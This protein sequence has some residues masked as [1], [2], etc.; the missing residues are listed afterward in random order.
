ME[1][2]LL[3]V[4]IAM[5]SFH[6][7]YWLFLV[8]APCCVTH[9]ASLDDNKGEKGYWAATAVG[10]V[11]AALLTVLCAG[12]LV[13]EPLLFSS[14]DF[15]RSTNLSQLC[16]KIFI[17]YIVNDLA[18][19]LYFGS[20]WPGW[21]SNL[22]HHVLVL[23]AWWQ[24]TSG[25]YAQGIACASMLCEVSTPFVAARW[26]LDK[27][28]M[29][30]GKM[31]FVNGIVMMLTFFVTRVCLYSYFMIPLYQM[32][33]SILSLPILNICVFLGCY[34]A[35]VILQNFWFFKIARGAW[36]VVSG[37]KT[38]LADAGKEYGPINDEM[39]Q[40]VN[41]LKELDTEEGGDTRLLEL[42]F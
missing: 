14:D 15:F 10:V 27:A 28:G 8:A 23:M 38:I 12:T 25:K 18:L 9:Y 19:S 13:N 5:A 20:R 3:T 37:T 35:G 7:M 16:C 1:Q 17:G 39:R 32:R 6:A 2:M 21:E 40:E 41:T 31:Y 4:G 42:K 26:Y 11:H 24:L 29:K 36:K 34:F 22:I 33:A 30:E